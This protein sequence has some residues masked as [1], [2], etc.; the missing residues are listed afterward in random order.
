MSAVSLCAQQGGAGE[1]QVKAAFLY[2]F[3]RF[4]EWPNSAFAS[5]SS[6]FKFCVLGKDPFGKALDETLAG[7]KVG[8]RSVE[9]IRARRV[10]ELE[11]CQVVFISSGETSHVSEVVAALHG[12]GALLVG[13]SEEFAGTGGTI[14]FFLQDNRV[15]FAINPEAANRVGLKISSKLLALATVVHDSSNGGKN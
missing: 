7:K 6:A 14:Q 10:Q 13:E 8:E 5:G 15:R 3:A 12:R 9:L 1:Y 4:V 11:G 2:N